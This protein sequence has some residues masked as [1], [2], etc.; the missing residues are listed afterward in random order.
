MFGYNNF[1]TTQGFAKH[2][3]MCVVLKR[4][5]EQMCLVKVTRHVAWMWISYCVHSL[6]FTIASISEE[7]NHQQKEG[8]RGG[9]WP[10]GLPFRSTGVVFLCSLSWNSLNMH[11]LINKITI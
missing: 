4:D 11:M 8:G 10:V 7:N 9:G 5:G 2:K 6:E 1:K 3:Y